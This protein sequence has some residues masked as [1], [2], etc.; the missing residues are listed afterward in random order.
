M[1][2]T[3]GKHHLLDSNTTPNDSNKT[4]QANDLS[5]TLVEST[6]IFTVSVA[7][8]KSSFDL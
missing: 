8:E 1:I 5:N 2:I 6:P 7:L 4:L 3:K